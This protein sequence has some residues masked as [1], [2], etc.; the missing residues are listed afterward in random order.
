MRKWFGLLAAVLL[1]TGCG[2]GQE[3]QAPTVQTQPRPRQVRQAAPRERKPVSQEYY[4]R[5]VYPDQLYAYYTALLEQWP[6]GL[7][8][9]MD[10]SPMGAAYAG[11]D[12]LVSVGFALED[13]DGDGFSELIIGAV[14]GQ[15]EDPQVFEVWTAPG[16]ETVRLLCGEPGKH[17]YLATAP[18]GSTAVVCRELPGNR[19]RLLCQRGDSLQELWSVRFGDSGEN[20]VLETPLVPGWQS[21]VLSGDADPFPPEALRRIKFYPF[22]LYTP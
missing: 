13:L 14:R 1:L 5:N 22:H 4:I 19:L 20:G 6:E 11:G 3:A 15:G 7:Y 21:T 8:R 9:E 16:E 12:P 17:Y 18:G 2:S 10:R